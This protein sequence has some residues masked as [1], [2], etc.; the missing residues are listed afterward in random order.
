M[1]TH[2][3]HDYYEIYYLL[4]GQRYYYIEN[5]RYLVEK[6]DILFINKYDIHQS[7]DTG[8]PNHER[9]VLYFS[10]EFLSQYHHNQMHLLLSPFH[11]ANKQVTF[12]LQ[13]QNDI[14]HLL[15]QMIQ[16]KAEPENPT[17]EIWFEALVVQLLMHAARKISE[18]P[19]KETRTMHAKMAHIIEYCNEHFHEPLH[20]EGIS[21]RFYISPYY[22]S[23]LFKQTTGF[24]FTEYINTLRIREAQ[25][26]LRETPFKMIEISEKVG[27]VNVS[28]FNR[29]F[30]QVT[31]MSPMEYRK[32]ART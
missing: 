4:S 8:K 24:T 15:F 3:Y 20:L 1:T 25:R 5:N 14:E 32:R 23:R 7:V 27:Y 19:R 28:H 2:H 29:K 12:N 16:I 22:F 9:I 10:D 17:K 11:G 13:E 26:L 31:R 6:G 30:K 18:S 21:S